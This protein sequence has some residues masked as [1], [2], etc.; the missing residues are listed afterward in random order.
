MKLS[1]AATVALTALVL[2]AGAR[3]EVLYDN[4]GAVT[5]GTDPVLGFG[6]L[7]DSFS[8]G[9]Q[10]LTFNSVTILIDGNPAGTGLT[11]I[12][13]N[14]DNGTSPGAVIAGGAFP[15]SFTS[16]TLMPLTA[17]GS[18]SLAANTRYWIE[19]TSLDNSS[20]NW[21]W[22]FD[23]S[24]VGVAGEFFSNQTGVHPNTG[25]PYQMEVIG[26]SSVPEPA[27]WAMML[28]GF[29]GLGVFMRRRSARIATA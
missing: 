25:G 18:I 22:S 13:L 3:A 12:T 27:T 19:L 16:A 14:A 2:G 28:V 1:L 24:G 6:P 5:T 29:G 20:V 23:T 9:S 21:A 15:D 26:T 4:L 10:A 7:A 11:G 17:T 8:T